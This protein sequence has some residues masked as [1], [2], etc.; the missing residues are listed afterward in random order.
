[1]KPRDGPGLFFRA[2]IR[3]VVLTV[4]VCGLDDGARW[5]YSPLSAF[6]GVVDAELSAE[7]CAGRHVFLHQ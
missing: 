1:M 5:F 2:L 4:F 3:A 6:V 7:F